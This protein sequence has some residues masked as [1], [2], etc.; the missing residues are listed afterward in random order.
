VVLLGP[1]SA[2][3]ANSNRHRARLCSLRTLLVGMCACHQDGHVSAHLTAVHTAL[4]RLDEVDQVRLGVL[5]SLVRTTCGKRNY[6]CYADPPRLDKPTVQWTRKINQKTVTRK[7]TDEQW[8]RYAEW[9]K[10]AKC[11]REL[12]AELE[13]FSM[14]IFE[15]ALETSTIHRARNSPSG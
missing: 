14:E 9:F 4:C 15:Q 3:R 8:Q 6:G 11:L 5:A 1:T 10:N 2:R 12:L 7:L 13:T